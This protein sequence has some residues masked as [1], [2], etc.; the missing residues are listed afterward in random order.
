MPKPGAEHVTARVVSQRREADSDYRVLRL[1]AP[2]VARAARP[3][4]FLMLRAFEGFDPLLG[5]PL[6]VFNLPADE[7]GTVEVLYAVVGRGT[8]II[9]RLEP[10]DAVKLLGPLGNGWRI[11][12]GIGEG[13]GGGGGGGGAEA[14]R[15]HLL[16]GG[17]CG[18][19]ALWL[20][21]KRLA[22][23]HAGEVTLVSAGACSANVLPPD[24]RGRLEELGGA[25][26][27]VILATEDGSAGTEGLATDAARDLIE[28]SPPA[29][30][31][32]AGPRA[33][34]KALAALAA[35]RGL[36]LQV[37][38]EERMACGVGVCRGCVVKATAPHPET[39]LYTRTVCADGPVFDA[40]EIDWEETR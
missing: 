34:L 21:A 19:A 1:E 5:R 13:I 12:E 7:P 6:A 16:V 10:G 20:L 14:G 36:R 33:M 26:V 27:T 8:R 24:L 30:L 22:A 37:S 9:E 11:G 40:N 17:G 31:Y 23:S 28:N 35:E 39:G 25:G 18:V 15:G 2:A 4:Q 29:Q 38:L 32:A 3:G